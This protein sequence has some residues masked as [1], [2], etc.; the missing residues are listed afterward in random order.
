MPNQFVL[1]MVFASLRQA[2][3]GLARSSRTGTI[4]GRLR[5]STD[6]N[7]GSPVCLLDAYLGY[8]SARFRLWAA[9]PFKKQR[10]LL[11]WCDLMSNPTRRHLLAKQRCAARRNSHCRTAIAPSVLCQSM[12]TDS[13][14]SA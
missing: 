2:A 10:W 6:S 3:V 1:V 4:L 13:T 11:I 7:L 8:S 12:F 9:P 5:K 14:N